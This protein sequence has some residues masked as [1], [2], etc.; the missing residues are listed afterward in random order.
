MTAPAHDTASGIA[1]DLVFLAVAGDDEQASLGF[2]Y[3][4]VRM[5]TGGTPDPVHARTHV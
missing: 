1:R 2:G 5:T 3:A 4:T